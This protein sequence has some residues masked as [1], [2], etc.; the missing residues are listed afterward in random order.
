MVVMA[1]SNDE[2]KAYNKNKTKIK[3]SKQRHIWNGN[4]LKIMEKE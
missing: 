1:E 3:S 2:P 4:E